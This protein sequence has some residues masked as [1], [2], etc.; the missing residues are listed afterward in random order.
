MQS[1]VLRYRRRSDF[2][3]DL[4]E[5]WKSK[6]DEAMFALD[7]EEFVCECIELG[8]LSKHAWQSLRE[9]LLKDPNSPAVD[10]SGATMKDALA[11][12]VESFQQLEKLIQQTKLLGYEINNAGA[13]EIMFHEIKQIRDKVNGIMAEPDPKMIAESMAAF[14]RG[15]YYSSEELLRAAQDGRPLPGW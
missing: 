14:Q 7:V 8:N 10:E 9:V 13:F 2:V 3:G 15:E 12:T 4:I 5:E 11:K 1:S 6:H